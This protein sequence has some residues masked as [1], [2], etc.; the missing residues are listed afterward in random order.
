MKR[1]FD[2]ITRSTDQSCFDEYLYRQPPQLE[3]DETNFPEEPYMLMLTDNSRF[4][5]S[6]L[7]PDRYY[8][9]NRQVIYK[10]YFL[11]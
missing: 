3:I 9:V 5:G 4:G 7:I 6:P 8:E 2:S 10:I 1:C 11:F